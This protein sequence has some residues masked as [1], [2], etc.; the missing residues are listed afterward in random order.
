MFL[1]QI[2]FLSDMYTVNRYKLS[3]LQIKQK[4]TIKAS[5]DITGK[6]SSRLS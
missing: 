1:L 6:M 4:K 5:T 3:N 2:K